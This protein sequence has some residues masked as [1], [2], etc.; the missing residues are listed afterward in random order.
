MTLIHALSG[1]QHQIAH[2]VQLVLTVF[3]IV[4]QNVQV[5]NAGMM[6]A[7]IQMGVGNA[8]KVLHV[9]K[10][11]VY[12]FQIVKIRNAAMMVVMVA[13]ALVLKDIFVMIMESVKMVSAHLIV[14]E[15]SA[16]MMDATDNAHLD[17]VLKNNALM[18]FVNL[19][20]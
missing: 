8:V 12:V 14:R 15:N 20:Q 5:N 2:L 10:I 7:A 6:G 17:A 3:V 9:K 18:D 13:A 16:V 19:Y 1:A 11:Y 4:L